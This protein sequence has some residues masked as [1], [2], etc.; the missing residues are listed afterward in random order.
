MPAHGGSHTASEPRRFADPIPTARPAYP[1]V[2]LV[3]A[4]TPEVDAGVMR[5]LQ[6]LGFSVR[7][8]R[9]YLELL[10]NG[11]LGAREATEGA[12]LQRATA[13][14]VLLRL[15]SR[16]VIMGNG[17]SPQ[18]F[19]A[20]GIE[21]VTRRLGGFLREEVEVNEM[22]AETCAALVGHSPS[23][24]TGSQG[25]SDVEVHLLAPDGTPTHPVLLELGAARESI[26]VMLRPLS[27]GLAY[28]S[29]LART[30]GRA[31]HHGVRV[32]VMVDAAPAD[33][34]FVDRLFREGVEES[35]R[36]SV[37]HSTPVAAHSYM[38][39]GRRAI[40]FPILGSLGR[41]SDVAVASNA[42]TWVKVQRARFDALWA[43]GIVSP[44]RRPSTR[45]FGWRLPPEH[46]PE[47]VARAPAPL[48][49]SAS[50]GAVPQDFP[51]GFRP[52][53]TA[54]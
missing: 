30:L 1:G 22:I 42:P 37:R 46:P 8:A 19:Q 49:A 25:S 28:R 20:V 18:R 15:L 31:A 14:R 21:V 2:D 10:R 12:G 33:R 35:A 26:D 9:L 13:Y 43:E 39:D 48:T 16:G 38:I 45:S 7:E 41:P 34:R 51:Q 44:R 32:R 52:G 24:V 36:L 11:P 47:P 40:R 54:R 4:G 23:E 17:R 3:S 27:A 6:L 53:R 29:A 5:A 50:R